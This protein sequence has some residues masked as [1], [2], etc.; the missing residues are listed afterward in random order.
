MDTLRSYDRRWLGEKFF[1]SQ[2]PDPTEWWQR[3][4]HLPY[5]PKRACCRSGA[6]SVAVVSVVAP[7]RPRPAPGPPTNPPPRYPTLQMLVDASTRAPLPYLP[8]QSKQSRAGGAEMPR[9]RR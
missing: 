5:V 1:D 8:K 3:H 2:G 9:G 4:E 6:A 7:D